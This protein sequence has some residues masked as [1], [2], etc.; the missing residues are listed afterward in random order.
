[1]KIIKWIYIVCYA[2]LA[3]VIIYMQHNVW[4]LSAI[5][6]LFILIG[7]LLFALIVRNIIKKKFDKQS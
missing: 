4:K 2:L 7:Y 5:K 6:Y 3:L 1:M